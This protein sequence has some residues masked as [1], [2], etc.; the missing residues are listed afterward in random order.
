MRGRGALEILGVFLK[1]GL[2]SFGGPVAHLG[3][4]RREFV[5]RRRWLD[6]ATYGDLV[7]LCQFLP[8]PASSQVGF[9]VGLLRGGW[10]GALAAWCGFTLPSVALLLAFAAF[11]PDLKGT[12]GQGLVHGLK[13]TAVAVVAQAVWDMG[14]RLCPDRR[15]T[16]VAIAAIALLSALHTVYAQLIV[17]ALGALAGLALYG[18]DPAFDVRGVPGHMAT[19]DRRVSHSAGIVALV[20]FG[21][22]LAGLP[23]M[24]RF[25]PML[26]GGLAEQALAS[27]DAFFRSGALVFGGG[28]VVLPLLQQQPLIHATVGQNE[29]LAGYGAA[30][31]VPG[32][33]FSFAAY[34][35]WMIAGAGGRLA[36]AVLATVAIFLPGLLLVV[37]ALP[38]WQ[39]LRARRSTAAMFAGVNAAVVGLLA[40]AL[41]SPVW[42]SAVH[43]PADFAIAAA[44]LLL[45][46]RW[47]T[48]PL[49]VVALCAA[50]GIGTAVWMA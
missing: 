18:R 9:S 34:L 29:L 21:V 12:I 35:G 47:K 10:L 13:L 33:L 26:G 50:A 41:Y 4:F 43:G 48:P 39:G 27:F 28:H 38:H 25:S 17:I 14:R 45:L 16:A 32:P 2:T 44:G 22:L 19:L 23:A 3:Y 6:E 30:Q 8:G 11:A 40:A 5:E 31:A 46:V 20:L 37:A 7:A 49:A 42:T 24:L 15:R 36:G 1:L